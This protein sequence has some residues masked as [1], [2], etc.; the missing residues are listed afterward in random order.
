MSPNSERLLPKMGA[1]EAVALEA[2]QPLEVCV[3]VCVCVC[4][5]GVCVRARVGIKEDWLL[6]YKVSKET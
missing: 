2:D 6:G 4:P 1:R 3:C 5:G